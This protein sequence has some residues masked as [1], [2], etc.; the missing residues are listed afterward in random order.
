MRL[1]LVNEKIYSTVAIK[2]SLEFIITFVKIKK[3]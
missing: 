2:L 1:G 3:K